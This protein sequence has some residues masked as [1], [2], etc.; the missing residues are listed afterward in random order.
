MSSE[1]SKLN[2]FPLSPGGRMSP[3]KINAGNLMVTLRS[4]KHGTTCYRNSRI[5][6]LCPSIPHNWPASSTKDVGPNNH[7]YKCEAFALDCFCLHKILNK[8]DSGVTDEFTLSGKADFIKPHHVPV[9]KS[10]TRN[11][12]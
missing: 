5:S 8:N 2:I 7:S 6:T 11:S 12:E 10:A 9:E 4:H 1:V 3:R